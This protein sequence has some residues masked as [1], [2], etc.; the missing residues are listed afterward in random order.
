MARKLS[1]S[2]SF[3]AVKPKS[4]LSWMAGWLINL[5]AGWFVDWL[6]FW[7]DSLAD[8]SSSSPTMHLCVKGPLSTRPNLIWRTLHMWN[9]SAAP[10][11]PTYYTVW[12]PVCVCV[13]KRR[14]TEVELER[15]MF[16]E[17]EAKQSRVQKFWFTSH[18]LWPSPLL[19][20]LTDPVLSSDALPQ[21]QYA[22]GNS[23]TKTH[24]GR[25]EK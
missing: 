12:L 19:H 2:R 24:T 3:S 7:A 25:R 20:S 9:S 18:K 23:N 10:H 16:A 14:D 11:T 1:K 17:K 4:S 22:Q 15:K 13:R 8:C 6:A 21:S 5:L